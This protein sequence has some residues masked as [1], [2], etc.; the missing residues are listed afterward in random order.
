MTIK[1]WDCN[2][3]EFVTSKKIDLFLKEVSSVCKKHGY[4]IS[5]EDVHGSFQI[6]KYNDGDLDWLLDANIERGCD[7]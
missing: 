6:C 2:T 5:H 1:R 7:A 4:L 3:N